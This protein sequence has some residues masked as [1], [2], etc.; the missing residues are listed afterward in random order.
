MIPHI[1][2]K[3]RIIA[4]I[5]GTFEK[6]SIWQRRASILSNFSPRPA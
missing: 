1:G 4:P 2:E 5:A 6:G 3:A